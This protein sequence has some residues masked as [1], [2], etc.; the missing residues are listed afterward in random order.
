MNAPSATLH[1]DTQQAAAAKRRAKR[2]AYIK[3]TWPLY[4]MVTPALILLA[5][6]A[7]Y[8]M[9]GL[10]IAFQ[11]FNPALGFSR[12]TWVG[13]ENF[14]RLFASPM[15]PR[16]LANTVILAVAKL[17]MGQISAITLALLLN[18]VRSRLFKRTMQTI[19]YLPHF[20][21]WIVIGGILI[22]LLSPSGLAGTIQNALGLEPITF[23]GSNTWFRPTL[24]VSH[25]WKEVGWSTIIYLAALTSIDP[26]LYEVAAIDGAGRWQRVRYISI[27]GILPIIILLASLSLGDILQAGFEQVLTLYNP[28]VYA[29]GDII[30]TY[31]YRIGLVQAQYGLSAAAGLFKSLIGFVLIIVSYHLAKKYA[32]YKIF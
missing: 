6:F 30:D 16:V 25:L 9:Y 28:T 13:L 19:I 12:S 20:L 27:P 29:T 21:S 17:T 32:G 31:V 15:F 2:I 7:Y 8:P 5:I 23:L 26:S 10:V 11:K 4:A 24:V 22:D 18:E 3:R 14:K 1:K